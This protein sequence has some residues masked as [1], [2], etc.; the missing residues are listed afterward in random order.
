MARF[1]VYPIPGGARDGYLIDVQADLL[2]HLA[3]RVVVPLEPVATNPMRLKDLNPIFDIAGAPHVL[4]T[5][6]IVAIPARD[7]KRPVATLRPHQDAI[8]RALDIL[9]TGL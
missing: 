5:Q 4:L 2:D 7:L 9:L 1:D 8:T 3:S 6:A